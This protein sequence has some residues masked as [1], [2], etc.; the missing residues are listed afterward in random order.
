MLF[1]K[2]PVVDV[3]IVFTSNSF[4]I[5]HISVS[6]WFGS[7]SMQKCW[8]RWKRPPKGDPKINRFKS[9]SSRIWLN[10]SKSIPIFQRDKLCGLFPETVF[11]FF[12]FLS[13]LLAVVLF[14]CFNDES[15]YSFAMWKRRFVDWKSWHMHTSVENVTKNQFGNWEESTEN[16][17]SIERRTCHSQSRKPNVGSET[18]QSNVGLMNISSQAENERERERARV[19]IFIHSRIV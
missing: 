17:P 16:S 1:R 7:I 8:K 13:P 3:P 4:L 10:T 12:L 18:Y 6:I 9:K 5:L 11:F 2:Y 14:R 19:R 15:T